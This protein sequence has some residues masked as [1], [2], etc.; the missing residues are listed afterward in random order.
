MWVCDTRTSTRWDL[1]ISPI[2]E[3]DRRVEPK[4]SVFSTVRSCWK[5]V[6][7]RSSFESAFTNCIRRPL[8]VS[9]SKPAFPV[10]VSDWIRSEL[11]MGRYDPSSIHT[12][13]FFWSSFTLGLMLGVAGEVIHHTSTDTYNIVFF[14]GGGVTHENAALFLLGINRRIYIIMRACPNRFQPELLHDKTAGPHSLTVRMTKAGNIDSLR[15]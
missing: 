7:A 15:P 12:R 9:D 4:I 10:L 2:H 1:L 13:V 14:C 8:C 11:K 3:S 5:I 6:I